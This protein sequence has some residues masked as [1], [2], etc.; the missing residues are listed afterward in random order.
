MSIS[1]GPAVQVDTVLWARVGYD[2][3]DGLHLMSGAEDDVQKME[4]VHYW[5]LNGRWY[6]QQGGS[7]Y[8]EDERDIFS[9]TPQFIEVH[10]SLDDVIQRIE[11]AQRISLS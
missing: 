1:W 6:V 7:H 8:S 2:S 3:K 4:G 9:H 11:T 5:K 10:D